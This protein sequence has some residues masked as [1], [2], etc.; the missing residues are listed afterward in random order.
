MPIEI[1]VLVARSAL[2]VHSICAAIQSIGVARR[3]VEQDADYKIGWAILP[4]VMLHGIF[5]FA[6]LALAFFEYIFSDTTPQPAKYTSAPITTNNDDWKGLV[7]DDQYAGGAYQ[8]VPAATL[9]QQL[10]SFGV[11][12]AITMVGVLYYVNEAGKQRGRLQALELTTAEVPS[13]AG[14]VFA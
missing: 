2:P 1:S 6:L 11:G 3:D 7:D 12:A 8:D 5:D 4:A 10:L 14:M 9:G 13:T